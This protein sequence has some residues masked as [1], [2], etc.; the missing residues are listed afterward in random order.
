MPPAV[1][2]ELATGPKASSFAAAVRG[3]LPGRRLDSH[4]LLFSKVDFQGFPVKLHGRFKGFPTV[5]FTG[6]DIQVRYLRNKERQS[7]GVFRV[8][9]QNPNSRRAIAPSR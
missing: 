7:I 4:Q 3:I 6:D 1:E 9:K 2:H 8:V 5:S